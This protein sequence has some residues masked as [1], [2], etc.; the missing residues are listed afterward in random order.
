MGA[1][2]TTDANNRQIN[3]YMQEREQQDSSVVKLLLL[4]PGSTG[5][6]TLF[7]SLQMVHNNGELNIKEKQATVRLIR[8]NIL[9]GIYTLLKQCTILYTKNS[10]IYKECE[11]N[12]TDNLKQTINY[13][14]NHLSLD[15]FQESP[16]NET[17]LIKLGQCIKIIW[18]LPCIQKTYS[19]RSNNFAISDN[20]EHFFS[21]IN[22]IFKMEYIPNEKDCLL[23]RS[24]TSGMKEYEYESDLKEAKSF[25]ILDVG[26]QV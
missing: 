2:C 3:A 24:K 6:S 13:I 25:M 11:L 12:M 26:G 1:A 4:G 16:L 10:N 7:K 17:Q 19:F 23:N 8:L 21:K 18:E 14:I 20:L 5:K 15:F 22:I 9:D